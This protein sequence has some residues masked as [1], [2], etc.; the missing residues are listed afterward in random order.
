M[1][2]QTQGKTFLVDCGG[3][4][5]S[6]AADITAQTLLS[7]GIR[8]LD[9]IIV[10]HYDRDHA[11]AL[12]ELLTRID[13]KCLILPFTQDNTEISQ[14]LQQMLPDRT[15]FV[16]EDMQLTL[17]RGAL[18]I[19]A[20]ASYVSGNESSMGIL[21]NSEKCAILITGDRNRETEALLMA[22]YDLPQLDALV[23]GHHG[24][25]T[26]TGEALLE[27][28][29]P[30]YAVIS[31]GKDNPYGHPSREVLDRLHKFNCTVLR[32]DLYGTIIFRR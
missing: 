5:D 15:V 28:T 29:T 12:D 13:T 18:T 9:G 20:P 3:S 17:D 21:L 7:Q 26:S 30:E 25:K 14:T 23:V 6:Q 16:S 31:V 8:T 4:N 22:H 2:L 11:G 1:L 10:T 27:K 24:S 19:F 32:T